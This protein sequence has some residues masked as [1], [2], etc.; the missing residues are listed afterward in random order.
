MEDGELEQNNFQRAGW[1]GS[2]KIRKKEMR[3]NSMSDDE[4]FSVSPEIKTANKVV[5]ISGKS[6]TGEVFREKNW[7]LHTQ[8]VFAEPQERE[9]QQEDLE[10]ED[11]AQPP[12]ISIHPSVMINLHIPMFK[13][14]V[15]HSK[16]I[17]GQLN[18]T[19]QGSFIFTPNQEKPLMKS[20]GN[21]NNGVFRKTNSKCKH[22]NKLVMQQLLNNTTSINFSKALLL[23]TKKEEEGN[24]CIGNMCIGNT[25]NTT[26]HNNNMSINTTRTSYPWKRSTKQRQGVRNEHKCQIQTAT[27]E[28]APLINTLKDYTQSTKLHINTKR[29]TKIRNGVVQRT[30]SLQS[31]LNL[32]SNTLSTTTPNKRDVKK[33]LN[34]IIGAH[35]ILSR[36][37]TEDENIDSIPQENASL[38]PDLHNNPLLSTISN[39]NHPEKFKELKLTVCKGYLLKKAKTT[40]GGEK[41]KQKYVILKKKKFSYYKQKNEIVQAVLDFDLYFSKLTFQSCDNSVIFQIKVQGCQ[42]MFEFKTNNQS[43][44]DSIY[45]VKR[46]GE[47]IAMGRASSVKDNP[48]RAVFAEQRFY[49]V[50][51]YIYIYLVSSYPKKCISEESRY[52]GYFIISRE[53][54]FC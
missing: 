26:H 41:W 14:N 48:I 28:K 33:S 31:T 1:K 43:F 15:M 54:Y 20:A 4:R 32:P 9:K 3:E 49:K 36:K 25:T 29:N 50:Y 30:I 39:N 51:I 5:R 10:D 34:H 27:V 18:N 52:R 45:W 13:T 47:H 2:S 37:G 44:D 42:K 23:H 16:S 12:K 7:K 46:I 19:I 17:K 8:S 38:V 24:M 22:S 21:L 53:K 11:D 6:K 40:F 35:K